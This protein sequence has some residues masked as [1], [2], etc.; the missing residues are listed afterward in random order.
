MIGKNSKEESFK[1]IYDDTYY[2]LRRFVER[3][4]QNSAIV[5]D[6]LQEVY[7]EVFRHIDDLLI[8]EN[9]IGWIYKTAE[10]KIRKLNNIYNEFL[11]HEISL[12]AEEVLETTIEYEFI[13]FEKYREVLKE[14]E[15]ELLMLKYN[16][17]YSHRELAEMTGKS[18]AGIKMKL[19][20]I[21]KKLR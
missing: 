4:S 9:Y 18:I 17:G 14:D 13:D 2:Y 10:N 8:H 11:I 1:N 20:R 21:I 3:R 5:D 15:Y 7:L 19:F 12:D 16:K 6:I